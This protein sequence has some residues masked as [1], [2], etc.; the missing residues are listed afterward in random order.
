MLFQSCI[1]PLNMARYV[2]CITIT[3]TVIIIF[4]SIRITIKMQYI[5]LI[6]SDNQSTVSAK[7]EVGRLVLLA[8]YVSTCM[9]VSMHIQIILVVLVFRSKGKMITSKN[10][11][12]SSKRSTLSNKSTI[13]AKSE[14]G[15]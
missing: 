14:E 2:L 5:S 3:V 10:A 11:I 15:R 9:N 8:V 13:T 4:T 6:L 12:R 1:L 7:S